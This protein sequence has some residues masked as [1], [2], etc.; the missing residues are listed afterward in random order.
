MSNTDTSMSRRKALTLGGR[1]AGGLVAA[2]SSPFFAPGRTFASDSSLPVKEIEEIMETTGKVMNGVLTIDLERTDLHVIGPQGIP[3]KPAFELLHEFHFQP[4]GDGRAF[5]NGDMT[6]LPHE[7]NPIIDRI[8]AGGL[9]FQALHQHFMDEH[10]Q[11][12]HP[13]F[14]G[15]GDPIHLAQA[16]IS[17]VK[18][19]GTPLPQSQPEHPTTPL[20][21]EQLAHIL[22]GTAEVGG[23]GV[24][25]VSIPRAETIFVA[26]VALKPEM[27]V[28]VTVA[29]EPLDDN[30]FAACAPDYALIAS[31]VNPALK[32]ARRQGFEVHCLYNQETAEEPQL[33]FSHNIAKGNAIDLARRVSRVLDKMHLKRSS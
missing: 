1:I 27:G 20:P 6:V 9:V 15:I 5:L 14:R 17:M 23:E 16:A 8:F 10:P 4:L 13:H 31:E 29:F 28:E 11:T 3:F 22:G 33:F 18:A 7:A 21:A 19:T 26:G 32:E 24:V 12:F 30:G 2:S 25:T